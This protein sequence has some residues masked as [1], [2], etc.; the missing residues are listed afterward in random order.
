MTQYRTTTD[1]N[2]DFS[3]D[4]PAL[5]KGTYTMKAIFEGDSDTYG[6]EITKTLIIQGRAYAI[7]IEANNEIIQ[8]GNTTTL[9]LSFEDEDGDPVIEPGQ[10]IKLYQEYVVSDEDKEKLV[11]LFNGKSFSQNYSNVTYFIGDDIVIDWGDGITTNYTTGGYSH[12]YEKD[13]KHIITISNVTGLVSSFASNSGVVG[14]DIPNTITSITNG[15][16][17]GTN[18]SEIFI[19]PSVK[20][21]DNTPFNGI[22]LLTKV[23]LSEGLETIGGGCFS[24]TRLSEITIPKSV[25]NINGIY[26]SLEYIDEIK[27]LWDTSETIIPYNS[28]IYYNSGDYKFIIPSGTTALYKTK[29]YPSNKLYER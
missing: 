7:S 12:T 28:N 13:G 4:L 16:F 27:F 6:S 29:G 2:G 15:A 5:E 17:T 22:Q 3:L 18:L 1:E 9:I 11:V 8:S 25:K 21:L 14:V 20:T 24:G 10:T 26:L 19:P 23:T